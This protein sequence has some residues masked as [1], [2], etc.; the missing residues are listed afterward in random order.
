MQATIPHI[1]VLGDNHENVMARD[2]HCLGMS[3]KLAVWRFGYLHGSFHA[4]MLACNVPI[5]EG[6]TWVLATRKTGKVVETWNGYGIDLPHRF[7]QV[8]EWLPN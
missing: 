1:K 6:F 7:R 2:G 8:I 4:V 5:G 3:D